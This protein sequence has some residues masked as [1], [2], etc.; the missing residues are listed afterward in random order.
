M[1]DTIDNLH[2]KKEEL[3]KMRL[4]YHA[5]ELSLV[6]VSVVALYAK[7][8]QIATNPLKAMASLNKQQA[9]LTEN[10]KV[11]NECITELDGIE[12]RSIIYQGI[13]D[14]NNMHIE[15][16]LVTD[17]IMEKYDAISCAIDALLLCIDDLESSCSKQE[18]SA[19]NHAFMGQGTKK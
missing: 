13:S 5:Y 17:A 10:Q 7:I 9:L 2:A 15:R 12:S 4:S 14:G 3:A 18:L 6:D 11:A 16:K 1:D 19:F 8:H